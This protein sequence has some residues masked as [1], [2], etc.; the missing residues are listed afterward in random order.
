MPL[1]TLQWIDRLKA[2]EREFRVVRI[3]M[4]RLA[5]AAAHDST[6]LGRALRV[7]EIGNASRRLEGTY[8]VRLFAEFETGLR[9]FWAATRVTSVP[10]RIAD[11]V[12][13]IAARQGIADGCR[14]NVHRVRGY[15]NRLV[16]QRE[17]EGEVIAIVNSRSHLC[18]FLGKMPLDW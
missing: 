8:V 6:I 4:D 5:V 15:R 17:E 1:E 3:A 9:L 16:H 10:D 18:T 11:I 13:S 2:I 12:D 7:R 14:M